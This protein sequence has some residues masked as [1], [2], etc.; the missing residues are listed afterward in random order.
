MIHA[1]EYAL[2]LRSFRKERLFV[3]L[4]FDEIYIQQLVDRM[5]IQAKARTICGS[6]FE[7]RRIY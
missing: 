2:S 3:H 6:S 7:E 1:L 4:R 5:P